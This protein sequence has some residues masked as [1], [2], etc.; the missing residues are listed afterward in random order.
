[1]TANQ[2]VSADGRESVLFAFRHSQQYRTAA[3][4]VYPTGLDSKATYRVESPDGKLTGETSELSGAFI[5][6]HGVRLTLA[7]DYDSTALLFNRTKLIPRTAA[8]AQTESGAVDKS[9]GWCQMRPT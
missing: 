9:Y 6:A 2:Y 3:P 8:S 7:G 4:V 5:K 1:M